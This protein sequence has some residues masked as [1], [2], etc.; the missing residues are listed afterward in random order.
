MSLTDEM[1]L[2]ETSY[3]IYDANERFAN[4]YPTEAQARRN[5]PPG[6][7]VAERNRDEYHEDGKTVYTRGPGEERAT[8]S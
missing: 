8:A 3:N 4:N 6:G 7:R 1:E 2:V 5:C